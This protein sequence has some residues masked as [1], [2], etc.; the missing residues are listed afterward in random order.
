MVASIINS[1]EGSE[2]EVRTWY[3]QGKTYA[4]MVKEYKRKYNLDVS[5]AIF[6]YRRSARGWERRRGTRNDELIPWAVVEEHR[7]HRHLVML[8][9]EARR[10]RFGVDEMRDRDVRDLDSFRELLKSSDA[11]VDYDPQTEDGFSLVPRE[12]SDSDIVRQ[13]TEA[14]QSRRRARS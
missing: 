3:F 12:P 2:P 8:R 14:S 13:P 6:S 7:W 4:W 9:L 5:P 11:V 1:T 10:R